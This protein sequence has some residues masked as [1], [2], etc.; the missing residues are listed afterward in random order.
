MCVLGAGRTNP[1]GDID[2]E[3]RT[4]PVSGHV[5]VGT[6]SGVPRPVD[7]CG[8]RP[9]VMGVDAGP[10]GRRQP[11]GDVRYLTL[12]AGA[13]QSRGSPRNGGRVTRSA[14]LR[15]HFTVPAVALD[16]TATGLSADGRTLV[17]IRPRRG[18]RSARTHP[19]D[20]RRRAAAR[21]AR[22]SRCDG[23]F[24][25]DAISPDG[26]LALPGPVRPAAIRPATPCAPTTSARGRLCPDPIVDP[27][28]PGEAMRGFPLTRATSPDGRWAYTL[29]DGGGKHPF[30]HALDTARPTAALHRPR[31][32]DRAQDLSDLRL[33]LDA[34]RQ[35]LNV[36]AAGARCWRS[37]REPSAS[38][39]STGADRRRQR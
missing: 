29:Y 21:A 23:D 1:R 12:P 14:L 36:V 35:S 3:V 7:G 5:S 11:S 17:L 31:R 18:S 8:G 33:S 13:G 28:E 27:R 20:P 2:R 19:R 9:S 39:G 6:R 34:D 30:V 24:S 37:A 10:G 4:S 22:S 32:A 16:G 38:S 26:R 15:G 25:F